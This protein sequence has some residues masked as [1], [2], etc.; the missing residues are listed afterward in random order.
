MS[1]LTPFILNNLIVLSSE[2]ETNS[3]ELN[4]IIQQIELLCS[5]II[6]S[7]WNVFLLY[8]IIELSAEPDTNLPSFKTHKQNTL[9]EWFDILYI[10]FFLGFFSVSHEL[11]TIAILPKFWILSIKLFISF[12]STLYS[13]L[14]FIFVSDFIILSFILFISLILFSI[15]IQSLINELKLFS[16]HSF[17][18]SFFYWLFYFIW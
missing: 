4:W 15:I 9:D 7:G 10:G 2:Q 8:I 11:Q 17:S 3:P 5:L 14:D 1:Y 12:S 6:K 16:F 18:I 13:I